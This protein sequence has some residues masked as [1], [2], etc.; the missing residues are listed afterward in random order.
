MAHDDHRNCIAACHACAD[1]CD[2]C[3]TACLNEPDPKRL[4]RCIELDIDC[5]AV[6][7]L[8]AGFMARGSGYDSAV[9]ALCAVLCEAC[10]EECE[11]HQY[12]HCRDC[13]AACRRCADECGRMAEKLPRADATTGTHARH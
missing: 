4:G 11:N 7:R 9:C 3:A 5:A 10:A 1:A 6:C 8:A 12:E 13:A 2:H